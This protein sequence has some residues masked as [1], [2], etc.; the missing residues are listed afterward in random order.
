MSLSRSDQEFLPAALEIL[1]SP[2]SPI[3]LRILCVICTFVVVAL[4]WSWIGRLDIIAS[5]HGKI[6]PVGR[7]KVIQP[8]VTG[9]VTA[10]LVHNGQTVRK[11]QGLIRLDPREAR[12]DVAEYSTAVQADEA[13][14]ARRRAELAAADARKW[15]PLPPIDWRVPLRRSIKRRQRR[16]LLADLKRFASSIASLQAQVSQKE[17]EQASLSATIVSQ[18][19]L[20]DIENERVA[21]KVQLRE[22]GAG[23]K[24]QIVKAEESLQMQQT[25][26]VQDEGRLADSKAAEAVIERNIEDERHKFIA[27]NAQKLE[28]ADR[29][30]DE[31]REKLA[32]ARV[33][34]SHTVLRS[35]IDG[36]AQAL[37]VTTIG[38][39]VSAGQELL[40]VVPKSSDLDIEAYLPNADRGFVAIGDKA[41]VKVASFPFTRYGTLPAR[42][43]GLARDAIPASMAMQ[44]ESDPT[45]AR[46]KPTIGGAHADQSLVYPVTLS[47]K[48]KVMNVDGALVPLAPGMAVTVEIRTGSRRIL[49]YLFSPLIKISS[50]ALHER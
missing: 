11:G 42:V 8:A 32:K 18:E 28:Q 2:P 35:P 20:V 48:R 19:K 31:A 9:K 3:R 12:A 33:L 34:L 27:D 26:L 6:H 10:I 15:P 38:Q 4:A 13:E 16:I 14:A 22:T 40:R 37:D 21:M 50:Q 44:A 17:T 30:A 39:I 49:Q 24:A 36:L 43:V 5:A 46:R 7:V 47:L 45:R 29:R 23:S 41:I 25:S 1:E